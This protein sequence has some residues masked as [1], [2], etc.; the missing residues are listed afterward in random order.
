M[1]ISFEGINCM[2]GEDILVSS[3][4]LQQHDEEGYLLYKTQIHTD[5]SPR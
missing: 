5:I 1:A 2:S 3:R 4:Y